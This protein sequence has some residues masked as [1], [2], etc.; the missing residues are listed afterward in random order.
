MVKI[1]KMCKPLNSY[2]TVC[3]FWYSW[4]YLCLGTSYIKSECTIRLLLNTKHY[5][6]KISSQRQYD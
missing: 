1:A 3:G 6:T 5:D 4:S 2:L